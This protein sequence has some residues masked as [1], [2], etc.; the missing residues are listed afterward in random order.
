MDFTALN[1]YNKLYVP[2]TAAA[3]LKGDDY[4]NVFG[5]PCWSHYFGLDRHVVYPAS[6]FL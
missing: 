5:F 6:R 1:P 4:E 3:A 2:Y